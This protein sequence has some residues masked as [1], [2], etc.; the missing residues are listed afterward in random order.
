LTADVTDRPRT[1]KLP[2]EMKPSAKVADPSENRAPGA[3]SL[4]LVYR[5]HADFVWRLLRHLGV[6]DASRDDVF[7]EVFLVVHRRL[8]DH[9]GRSSLSTWLFGITRNV[10]WHHRRSHA[11]HLRRLTVAP[12]PS[13]GPGPEEHVARLEAHALVDR[14]LATLGEDQRIAFALADIEGLRAPEIAEQL[15]LNLNTLYSRL[16]AVRKQFA[17]FVAAAQRARTGARDDNA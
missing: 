3:P 7:H 2:E 10:V 12:A 1:G 8:A 4:E 14:F 13:S 16:S 17:Q 9:D 6:P 15:G 5:E 11:R